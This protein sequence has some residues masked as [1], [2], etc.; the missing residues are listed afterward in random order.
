MTFSNEKEFVEDV[1]KKLDR[2][3]EKAPCIFTFL[4]SDDNEVT[5]E[6]FLHK[7]RIRKPLQHRA[8]AYSM[9]GPYSREELETIVW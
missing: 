4:V 9:F 2:K 6:C 1:E 8:Y 3:P 7:E 5:F